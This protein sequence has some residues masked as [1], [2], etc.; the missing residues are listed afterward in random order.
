MAFNAILK[1]TG[2]IGPVA[3]CAGL[4][5]LSVSPLFRGGNRQVVMIGLEAMGLLILVALAF[6]AAFPTFIATTKR[7]A[8]SNALCAGLSWLEWCLLAS[9]IV[10]GLIYLTPIPIEWWMETGGRSIYDTALASVGVAASSIRPLSLNPEATWT[11]LLAGL[12][13]VAAYLLGRLCSPAQLRLVCKIL[14]ASAFFQVAVGVLQLAAGGESLLYFDGGYPDSAIGTFAN[15]SHFANYLAMILPLYAWLAFATDAFDQSS[16]VPYKN[17]QS[18]RG[19]SILVG[20][21]LW[22][23]GGFIIVLGILASR[24]RGAALT[25]L[26]MGLLAVMVVASVRSGQTGWRFG[27]LLIAFMCAATVA[28]LGVDFLTSRFQSGQFGQAASFRTVLASSTLVGAMEFWPWGAGWGAYE[29]VYPRFQPALVGGYV[30]HAHHDY[31]QVLFDGGIFGVALLALWGCLFAWGAYCL[32]RSFRSSGAAD[33]NTM[34]S[35]ACG[36]ALMGVMLHAIAEF[37]MHIPANAIVAALLAGIYL[38]SIR[39]LR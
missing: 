34:L 37:S 30:E 6:G 22:V 5:L 15:R 16:R 26:P 20:R 11:S 10:L 12:P 23:V 3:F 39:P 31:V 25:G 18:I 2:L 36:L 27:A 28:L 1:K 13:L 17:H 38:R 7:R 19:R 14:V 9:P 33:P 35:L 24:S 21:L 32:V 29:S 4:V 8:S